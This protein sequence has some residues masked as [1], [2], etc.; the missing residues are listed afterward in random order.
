LSSPISLKNRAFLIYEQFLEKTVLVQKF[1]KMRK[2]TYFMGF[3]RRASPSCARL[4]VQKCKNRD[5]PALFGSHLHRISG[6]LSPEMSENSK[7]TGHK[8]PMA[9]KEIFV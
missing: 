2:S 9:G 4:P 6:L 1:Q 5:F 8:K 3:L 7:P